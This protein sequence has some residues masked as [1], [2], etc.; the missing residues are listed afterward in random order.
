MA[1][2]SARDNELH[3][4]ISALGDVLELHYPDGGHAHAT[5][6]TIARQPTCVKVTAAAKRLE[7]GEPTE[8]ARAALAAIPDAALGIFVHTAEGFLVAVS[9]G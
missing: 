4:A 2:R 7:G 9:L 5:D 3:N 8:Q 1:G 6:G